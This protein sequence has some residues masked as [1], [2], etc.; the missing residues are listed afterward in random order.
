LFLR[1]DEGS[2]AVV[3]GRT[4]PGKV[5]ER[6]AEQLGLTARLVRSP[7]GTAAASVLAGETLTVVVRTDL[8]A[9]SPGELAYI[10][11]RGI[12]LARPECVALASVPE[13]DRPRIIRALCAAVDETASPVDDPAVAAL[14][15]AFAGKL[16]Q[17]EVLAWRGQLTDVAAAEVLA[18]AAFA[19]IEHAALQVAAVA[20]G[21]SRTALRAIARL[22]PDGRRPPG[23][24]RLE[25]FESYF[26]SVPV[27][28]RLFAFF[29]SEDFGRV[30][31]ASA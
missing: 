3:D 12:M 15:S 6:V 4:G 29:A 17:E 5:F 14:A 8:L 21:D 2:G 16:N 27:L 13:E 9:A 10:Y 20:A 18:A 7:D 25:E 1:S 24:A 28:G 19:D 30:L 26:Q 22:I 23:V 31:A 11:A